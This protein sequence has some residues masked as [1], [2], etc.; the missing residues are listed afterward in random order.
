MAEHPNFLHYVLTDK[1]NHEVATSPRVRLQQHLDLVQAVKLMAIITILNTA[2]AGYVAYSMTRETMVAAWISS[3]FLCAAVMLYDHV[4]KAGGAIPKS[5][6]GR[7]VARSERIALLT[8]FIFSSLPLYLASDPF[9]VLTFSSLFTVSMSAGLMCTL[10]RH[11]R[12]VIRYLIGSLFPLMIHVGLNF[13]DRMIAVTVGICMLMITIYFGANAS[14]KLYLMEVKSIE[15]ATQLRDILEVSLDGSGQAFAVRSRKGEI[16]FENALYTRLK[17]A[18][19]AGDGTNRIVYA[20]DRYWQTATY[21]VA[22]VG[23]VEVF[24][25]VTN[26]EDARQEAETLREEAN[27]ASNS[28]TVFLRS[29]S[30]ELLVPLRTIRMQA[31][32]MDAGSRIPVT[33]E[34]MAEAAGQ[35]RQLTEVLESRVAHII[36]FASGEAT[37]SA[38]AAQIDLPP[39]A[40]AGTAH[41][42]HRLDALLNERPRQ[43]RANDPAAPRRA[44]VGPATGG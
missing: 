12:L 34:D 35:I 38:Q 43:P 28:R 33:R 10:P 25:D 41:P 27:E 2:I 44:S 29:I 9:N 20:L 6:S 23:S 5:V 8:G 32:L 31:S 16:V 1:P 24:T 42:V 39:T 30:A 3:N 7:Y 17:A 36:N 21:E 14:F 37:L 26:I 15:A 4:R 40:S 13:D 19:G 11:P 22:S 18:L